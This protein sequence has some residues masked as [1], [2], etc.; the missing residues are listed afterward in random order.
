MTA[1]KRDR[2]ADLMLVGTI[3]IWSLNFTV[4]R[5]VLEHGFKPLAYSSMRYGIA[6]T[7]SVIADIRAG[8]AGAEARAYAATLRADPEARARIAAFVAKKQKRE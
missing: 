4:T 3:L 1:L 6:A 5:Y 7:K 2:T 8:R